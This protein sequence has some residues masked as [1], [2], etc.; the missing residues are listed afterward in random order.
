[1]INKEREYRKITEQK[2][3]DLD[4]EQEKIIGGLGEKLNP[5]VRLDKTWPRP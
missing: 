1:V 4:K 3:L 2:L 5:K